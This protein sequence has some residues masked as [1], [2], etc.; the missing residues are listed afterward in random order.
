MEIKYR[1]LMKEYNVTLANEDNVLDPGFVSKAKTFE[2]KLKN[3]QLTDEEIQSEDNE[4]VELFNKH[5]LTEEDSDDVKIAKHNIAIADAKVEI[6]DAGTIEVLTALQEKFKLLPEVQPIIDKKLEKLQKDVEK[7]SQQAAKANEQEE[8]QA[9]EQLIA[10]GK[11]EIAKTSFEDLQIIG[12]KYKDYPE[13][14]EIINKRHKDEKPKKDHE[15]LAKKLRSK[16]EWTYKE[17]E[18]IGIKPTD[19]DMTVAGVRLEKEFLLSVYS[20]RR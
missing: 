9:R 13:L 11:E 20:V 14:V 2:E 1:E 7:S 19:N 5:D 15:E 10:H 17:L 16:A 4:L 6:A 3:N 8:K 12:E 18:A